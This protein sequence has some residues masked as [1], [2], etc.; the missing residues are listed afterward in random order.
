MGFSQ[1]KGTVSAKALKWESKWSVGEM[2]R[3]PDVVI[4]RSRRKRVGHDEIWS[5]TRF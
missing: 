4:R 1:A 2:E 5:V 3:R